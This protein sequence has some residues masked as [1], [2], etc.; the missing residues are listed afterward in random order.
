MQDLRY[1]IIPMESLAEGEFQTTAK[2]MAMYLNRS[3]P[4]LVATSFQLQSSPYGSVT[5]TIRHELTTSGVFDATALATMTDQ[6]VDDFASFQSLLYS[7]IRRYVPSR[8]TL[9]LFVRMI[10]EEAI[11]VRLLDKP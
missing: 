2:R 3:L 1:A 6:L 9:V 8:E 11:V 4:E 5:Q 10:G 7:Q